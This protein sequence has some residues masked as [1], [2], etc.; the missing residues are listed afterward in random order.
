MFRCVLVSFFFGFQVPQTIIGMDRVINHLKA[1][2]FVV[3]IT[4]KILKFFQSR[5]TGLKFLIFGLILN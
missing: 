4:L 2:S 5:T 3:R 1:L